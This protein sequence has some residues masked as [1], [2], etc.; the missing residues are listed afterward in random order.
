MS[1]DNEIVAK[2]ELLIRRPVAEVFDAFVNPDAI[3]K[4]WFNRTSGTLVE[5]TSVTWYWDL[6][7]ASTE[8]RVL[9]LEQNRRIYIEWDVNTDNPS[10]V[11]WTFE[12]RGDDGTYVSVVNSGFD[13]EADDVVERVV[14]S[15]GGFALVLAAAKA[16]LE[17][18]VE[19]NIVADRF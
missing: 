2:I 11:E 19:L 1:P 6:Y 15:T 12:D 9:A 18:G 17:H 5:D 3:T 16:Y 14:D 13:S 4:F 10:R 7:E 8:V